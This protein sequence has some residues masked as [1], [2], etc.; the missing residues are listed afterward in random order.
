[1]AQLQDHLPSALYGENCDL[2]MKRMPL[3]GTRSQQCE[4]LPPQVGS[5]DEVQTGL[6]WFHQFCGCG[7]LQ[8]YCTAYGNDMSIHFT[9]TSSPSKLVTSVAVQYDQ[10]ANFEVFYCGQLNGHLINY[11]AV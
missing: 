10:T 11:H 8:M 9:S 7:S 2:S 5:S 1:M 6:V 3:K 4:H